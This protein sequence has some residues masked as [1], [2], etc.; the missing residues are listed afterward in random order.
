MIVWRASSALAISVI[1]ALGLRWRTVRLTARDLSFAAARGR[2]IEVW[3]PG[4][5]QWIEV[6][7]I[8]DCTTFQARRA[9]I[10]YQPTTRGKPRLVHT[11][12]GS[13]VAVGRTL[14][15]VLEQYQQPDGSMMIPSI[16]Q[17][18][19]GGVPR[20]GQNLA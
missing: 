2:D 3:F 15:A 12:N 10:R 8:S 4:M 18:Y 6:A 17:P 20:I 1:D 11:L 13:G 7:S 16:L 14:A 5:Q 19:V 9:N